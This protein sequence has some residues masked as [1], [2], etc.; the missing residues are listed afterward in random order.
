MLRWGREKRRDWKRRSQLEQVEVST[1][2]MVLC[3]PWIFYAS[4]MLQFLTAVRPGRAPMLAAGTVLALGFVQAVLSTVAVRRGMDCYLG[5]GAAP[6]RLLAA[7]VALFAVT[8]LVLAAM[9]AYGW[10]GHAASVGMA[11]FA[12]VPSLTGVHGLLV[13]PRRGAAHAALAAVPVV[14]ALA[15]AGMGWPDLTGILVLLAVGAFAGLFT[16]RCSAWYIAVMR[17]LD[18]ARAVHSRLAVAEERL[19]F[20]RDLHDV[21]GRNLSVIALKSELATQLAR[22]GAPSA[23][24]QMQEVQEL[25]RRSQ[26]EIRE[27]VRGYR[28]A[29]LE[30]ELAGARGVLRAAGVDC[31]IESVEPAADGDVRSVLGWVVR[32]GTT[33]VL[34]HAEARECLIRLTVEG[35]RAV[36]LIENDGLRP[37]LAG[38][39]SGLAGLAERLTALGGTLSAVRVEA[40]GVFRLRAEVPVSA[41]GGGGTATDAKAAHGTE[42]VRARGRA[43]LGDGTAPG[44]PGAGPA[45]GPCGATDV[46]G[47][48]GAA[49]TGRTF[50]GADKGAGRGGRDE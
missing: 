4:G 28:A 39:G 10:A 13:R 49:A 27:V 42:D 35:G 24:E 15:L 38:R 3:T 16:P 22:R 50:A 1:R 18:E 17:E 44:G 43:P 2:W 25:A 5:V 31:R 46:A 20:G 40:E 36:L 7:G 34:R 6:R 19:R 26:S 21:M 14:G 11:L 29:G 30:T 45:D 41:A 8:A 12:S 23:V 33:N 9:V 37:V 32:E 47:R 48:P